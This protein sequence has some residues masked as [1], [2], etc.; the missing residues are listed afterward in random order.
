MVSEVS[1]QSLGPV[2][3][4]PLTRQDIIVGWRDGAKISP[5]WQPE[6]KRETEERWRRGSEG[7]LPVT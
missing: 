2:A 3:F 6:K 7:T 1:V 5:S 4:G